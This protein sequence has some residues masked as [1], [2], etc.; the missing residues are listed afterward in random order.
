MRHMNNARFVREL[1]FARFDFYVRTGLY[2]EMQKVDGHALQGACTI[3]YRRP[4]GTFTF[5][6]VTTRVS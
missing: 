1:D 5:Y 6:K 4:I 2:A 3:R